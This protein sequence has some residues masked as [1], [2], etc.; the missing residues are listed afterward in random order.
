MLAEEE[1]LRTYWLM[2]LTMRDTPHVF[3][4]PFP[5]APQQQPTYV[6]IWLAVQ[7]GPLPHMPLTQSTLPTLFPVPPTPIA[8]LTPVPPVAPPQ[9]FS[10][11]PGSGGPMPNY[12][13]APAQPYMIGYPLGPFPP[14]QQYYAGPHGHAKEDSEMAKPDKFT[15]QDPLKLCPFIVSCIMAFD[16]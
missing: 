13:L 5:A 7:S 1:Y 4:P 9:Y 10:Y 12:Y 16:S 6:P 2:T 3:Y 15:G 11:P 14:Y 8:P